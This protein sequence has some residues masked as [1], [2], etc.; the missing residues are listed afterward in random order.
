MSN[1]YVSPYVSIIPGDG[2][3]WNEA[4]TFLNNHNFKN[5]VNNDNT[6]LIIGV[7]IK[8]RSIKK[9]NRKAKK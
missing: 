9:H 4:T 7:R 5:L 1:R 6:N 3:M 2:T 8:K